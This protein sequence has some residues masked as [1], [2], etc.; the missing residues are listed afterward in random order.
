MRNGTIG[1]LAFA[2][3]L[4]V[5]GCASVNTSSDY[6]PT[7]DFSK[8]A[9]FKV[10]ESKEIK[11]YLVAERIEDAVAKQLTA[12]GL[13]AAAENPDLLVYY[14]GRVDKQTRIEET[15]D[16]YVVGPGWGGYNGYGVYG[17]G[18]TT[19]VRETPVG[20]LFVDVVDARQKRLVW[21]GS[22]N[23]TL[24]PHA[25]ADDKDWRVNNAVEKMFARFPVKK[26]S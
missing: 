10:V 1:A 20:M 15:Q 18:T 12:R 25:N 19:T 21:Q 17:G 26:T 14:H 16:P 2:A 11:S 4:G 7:A 24:D 5:V 9:T 6:D 13:K 3:A 8:Y 22:A 23:G